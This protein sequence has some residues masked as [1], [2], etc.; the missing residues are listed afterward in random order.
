M[1]RPTATTAS[2]EAY[3]GE[4]TSGLEPLTCPLRVS[5]STPSDSKVL[6]LTILAPQLHQHQL[7]L[8]CS[9]LKQSA[10]AEGRNFGNWEPTCRHRRVHEAHRLRLSSLLQAPLQSSHDSLSENPPC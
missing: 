5:R 3:S 8:G 6:K 9:L 1:S 4:P 2:E 10:K 7:E